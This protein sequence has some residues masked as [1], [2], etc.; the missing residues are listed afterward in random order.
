MGAHPLL[1]KSLLRNSIVRAIQLAVAVWATTGIKPWLT[2]ILVGWADWSVLLA[3]AIVAAVLVE[4]GT[5]ITIGFPRVALTWKEEGDP[6]D[7]KQINLRLSE[8]GQE[9]LDYSVQVK[10]EVASLLGLAVVEGLRRSPAVVRVIISRSPVSIV[11]KN[12]PREDG[13][14]SVETNAFCG[15]DLPL[16]ANS[17]PTSMWTYAE[18]AFTP[19]TLPTDVVCDVQYKVVGYTKWSKI[20]ACLLRPG[21]AMKSLRFRKK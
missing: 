21:S 16:R 9:S 19:A 2:S 7:L 14:A 11:L 20:G 3:S 13:I 17:R 1:V 10:L 8:T 18:M 4:I 5:F 6:Q 12:V 15:I